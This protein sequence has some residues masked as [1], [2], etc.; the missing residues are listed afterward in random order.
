MAVRTMTSLVITIEMYPNLMH[1]IHVLFFLQ[2]TEQNNKQ[3]WRTN[4]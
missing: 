2:L 4:C 3:S 1:M